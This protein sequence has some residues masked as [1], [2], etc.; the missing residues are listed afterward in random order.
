MIKKSKKYKKYKAFSLVELMMILLVASL[1]IAAIAPVVTKKHFRLPSLV[2]HGAYMCYYKEG[3]LREAKWAGKFQQQQL[4]DRETENCVFTPPKKAAFFQVSA[5]GGGGGGGDS[6]YTG[7]NWVST[8]SP[9]SSLYPFGITKE[10]IIGLL[11]IED[12]SSEQTDAFVDEVVSYMGSLLGYANSIGSGAGGTIG[13][14]KTKDNSYCSEYGT[15]PTE[16][17]TGGWKSWYGCKWHEADEDN[18]AQC[19]CGEKWSYKSVCDPDETTPTQYSYCDAVAHECGGCA[20]TA[21]IPCSTQ[22]TEIDYCDYPDPVAPTTTTTPTKQTTKPTAQGYKTTCNGGSSSGCAPGTKSGCDNV[23][24]L[25]LCCYASCQYTPEPDPDPEV[26]VEPAVQAQPTCYTKWGEWKDCSYTK[27]TADA[28]YITRWR[29]DVVITAGECHQEKDKKTA[30]GEVVDYPESE[31]NGT[32]SKCLR[33]DTV[34]ETDWNRCITHSWKCA[35]SWTQSNGESGGSGESCQSSENGIPGGLE[36]AFTAGKTFDLTTKKGENRDMSH[37]NS[38]FG[39]PA[40]ADQGY[41]QCADGTYQHSC[42]SPSY[43]YYQIYN[44]DGLSDK[45]VAY[46][47]PEGGAGG[48]RDIPRTNNCGG[49]VDVAGNYTPKARDG[50]CAADNMVATTCKGSGI[51]GYCLKHHYGGDPVVDGQYNYYYGYDSNYLGYG[52]AGSPG[53]FRTTIVRSMKDRDLTIKVGRG[54]SAAPI[55]SGRSGITGSTTSMGDIITAAGGAGGGGQMMRSAERLPVYNK[56]RYEKESLCYYYDKYNLKDVDGHY[57]YNTPEA[58]KLRDTLIAQPDYCEGL[59]NNQGAYN[60]YRLS[61][62]TAGELPTASGTFTSFMNVAFSKAS[63]SGLLSNFIKFGRGGTGGG[64]E[65]RC[66]AGRHDIIFEEVTLSASVFVDK[67][68]ATEYAVA[69]NKYVPDGCRED[70]SNVP[71][72]PGVDGALLIKW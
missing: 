66:W 15:K 24:G 21:K 59:I 35:Y 54:G 6:G 33:W 31:C 26:P 69:H 39:G 63:G 13:L 3:Q 57:R 9:S 34:Y 43:A 40:D 61:G 52:G 67:E 19:V 60:F 20:A 5:I 16:K 72:S 25:G 17:C 42:E 62:T 41:A 18:D 14:E 50:Y 36:L 37:Q 65:H 12:V 1:I 2:N 49:L 22:E 48:H 71:A 68:H 51:Y 27:C 46:S 32:I 64:V 28:P 55:D 44:K 58:I 11:E 8:Y 47:A 23:S 45:V 29:D 53:E 56:E 38:A 30:E 4:Y 10:Q 7:G 70:Y